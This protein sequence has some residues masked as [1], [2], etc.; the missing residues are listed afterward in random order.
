ML[1]N[2][3]DLEHRSKIR[4]PRAAS[5]R[6]HMELGCFES[7]P[8]AV[9]VTG[10][11]LSSRHST[12]SNVTAGLGS[13]PAGSPCSPP[14]SRSPQDPEAKCRDRAPAVLH[15]SNQPTKE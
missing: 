7:H 2:A 4:S 13:A 12:P 1:A 15:E 10:A 11:P 3:L 5:P 8:G 14:Q 6:S 9:D